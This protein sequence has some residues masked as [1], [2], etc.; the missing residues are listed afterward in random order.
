MSPE[1]T[2]IRAYIEADQVANFNVDR[3]KG[4]Y[5]GFAG[6][7]RDSGYDWVGTGFPAK[8]FHTNWVRE[9]RVAPDGSATAVVCFAGEVSVSGDFPDNYNIFKRTM[10]FQRVGS[11]PPVNQKGPARAPL[12]SVFGDWYTSNFI[13]RYP[14]MDPDCAT[15][16]PPVDKSPVSTPGWPDQLGV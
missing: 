3:A 4:S 13:T 8:G 9:F 6:A 10:V 2:Y 16:P 11:S 7:A 5:L 14:L 15:D 12:V 1:G